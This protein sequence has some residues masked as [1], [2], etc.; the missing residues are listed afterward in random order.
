MV[1][2]LVPAGLV[3]PVVPAAE[4]AS[5]IAPAGVAMASSRP[6]AAAAANAAAAAAAAA[7][8][9]CLALPPLQ[10]SSSSFFHQIGITLSRCS[11]KSWFVIVICPERSN[12][13]LESQPSNLI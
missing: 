13:H 5:A 2:P 3:V 8:R 7:R 4:A 12:L 10:P 1:H 11:K 6:V 9:R